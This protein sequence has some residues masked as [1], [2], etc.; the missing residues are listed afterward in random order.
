MSG[1]PAVRPEA[2]TVLLSE[3]V[4]VQ[5]LSSLIPTEKKPSAWKRL[6]SAFRR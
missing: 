1:A 6:V 5:E 4:Q 2:G 3:H